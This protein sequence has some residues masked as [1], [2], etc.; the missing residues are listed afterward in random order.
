MVRTNAL[1]LVMENSESSWK[2]SW[3][4][5]HGILKSPKSTNPGSTLFRKQSRKYASGL[6]KNR[7]SI[8]I[9]TEVILAF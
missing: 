8:Y 7:V 6:V 1:T 9:I 5:S 3:P 4:E 2:T